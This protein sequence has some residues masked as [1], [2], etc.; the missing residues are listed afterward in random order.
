MLDFLLIQELEVYSGFSADISAET[1]LVLTMCYLV[2]LVLWLSMVSHLHC[3]VV[4]SGVSQCLHW[5]LF[6]KSYLALSSELFPTLEVLRH[7]LRSM[8]LVGLELITSV[9]S[10]EA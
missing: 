8:F 7:I 5:S 4:Y 6:N 2:S 9:G 3:L 10:L 1:C